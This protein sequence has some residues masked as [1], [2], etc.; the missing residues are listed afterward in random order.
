MFHQKYLVILTRQFKNFIHVQVE[1]LS[2]IMVGSS[3]DVSLQGN[4]WNPNS[5]PQ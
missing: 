4:H 3:L 5:Q 2:M 1:D